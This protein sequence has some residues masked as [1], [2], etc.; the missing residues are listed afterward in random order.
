MSSRTNGSTKRGAKSTPTMLFNADSLKSLLGSSGSK[1]P[2][3]N[4]VHQLTIVLT[5][6]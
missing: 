1:N 6:D 3:D 5:S 4:K 2:K